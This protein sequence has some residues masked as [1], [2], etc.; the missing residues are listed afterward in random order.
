[1]LQGAMG[2]NPAMVNPAAA[3][4]PAMIAMLVNQQQQ[5]QQKQQHGKTT[6]ASMATSQHSGSKCSASS[7][8]SKVA[9]PSGAWIGPGGVPIPVAPAFVTAAG[10][11]WQQQQQ[12]QL[13]AMQGTMGG[14]A[15]SSGSL[16]SGGSRGKHAAASIP[17]QIPGPY[18]AAAVANHRGGALPPGMMLDAA[19]FLPFTAPAA[20]TGISAATTTAGM[21]PGGGG[22]SRRT[23]GPWAGPVSQQQPY[24]GRSNMQS[25]K[26]AATALPLNG[27][28]V[29]LLPGMVPFIGAVNADGSMAYPGMM[30]AAGQ[31]GA[32]KN[33]NAHSHHNNLKQPAAGK[34]PS[35]PPGLA[36]NAPWGMPMPQQFGMMPLPGLAPGLMLLA[37]QL[38][39]GQEQQHANGLWGQKGQLGVAVEGG[40]NR[41]P[42][43]QK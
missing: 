34:G 36:A 28:G 33:H 29:P 9:N 20:A 5:Q 42:G 14:A 19:G 16:A 7:M 15:A 3:I 38:A 24:T 32:D 25:N 31:Q 41:R 13:V 30:M 4:N 35:M 43:W 39:A 2:I 10:V 6:G 1:M 11:P 22:G 17:G 23:G 8:H 40:G 26:G 27:M 21:P 12:Q 18:T 37:P